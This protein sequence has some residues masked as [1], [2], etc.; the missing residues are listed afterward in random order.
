[1]PAALKQF[2][3]EFTLPPSVKKMITAGLSVYMRL[4]LTTMSVIMSSSIASWTRS[5]QREREEEEGQRPVFSQS[6]RQ[7][8]SRTDRYLYRELMSLQVQFSCCSS[9]RTPA[10]L[11]FWPAR[12]T[13]DCSTSTWNATNGRSAIQTAGISF[14]FVKG[15]FKTLSIHLFYSFRPK[16]WLCGQQPIRLSQHKD[17]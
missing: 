8:G 16:T 11:L 17:S 6:D 2:K 1:M 5:L 15:Q 12:R 13:M 7:V 9:Q 4:W 14:S 3:N 10:A